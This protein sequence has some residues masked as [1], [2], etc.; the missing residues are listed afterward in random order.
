MAAQKRQ[1]ITPKVNL[2]KKQ[3]RVLRIQSKR[4]ELISSLSL[5]ILIFYCI[6]FVSTLFYL[7]Y[8]KGSLMTSER[9]LEDEKK[10]MKLVE[11]VRRDYYLLK[12]RS[13]AI[14]Q[15]NDSIGTHQSIIEKV[16][17]FF[18][19]GVSITGMTVSEEGVVEFRVRA[20][21]IDDVE[22]LFTAMEREKDTRNLV[23]DYAITNSLSVNESGDYNF[24]MTLSFKTNDKGQG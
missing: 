5:F 4:L 7:G 17:G 16:L 11:E 14:K 3:Q 24:G 8:L 18:P 15:V 13:Q 12:D 10:K 9:R 2:L 19:E 1:R 22:A 6:G 21:S 20:G 23:I